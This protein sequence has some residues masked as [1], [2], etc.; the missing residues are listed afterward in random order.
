[1]SYTFAT[2]L[3]RLRDIAA[4]QTAGYRRLLQNTRDG[5]EAMKAQDPVRFE[6]LLSEQVETLRQLGDLQREREEA[7]REVGVPRDDCLDVRDPIR[8]DGVPF[9]YASIRPPRVQ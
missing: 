3:E 1:M 6:T 8:M 7:I 2:A 9:S 5:I 4:S